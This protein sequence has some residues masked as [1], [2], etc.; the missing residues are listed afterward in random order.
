MISQ[1]DNHL[2]LVMV[3]ASARLQQWHSFQGSG[4]LV[5]VGEQRESPEGLQAWLQRRDYKK[6]SWL[7]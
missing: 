5:R 1:V 3:K 7:G 6:E 4:Q 2:V